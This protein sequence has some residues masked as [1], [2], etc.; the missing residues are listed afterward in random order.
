MN[1]AIILTKLTLI[2]ADFPVVNLITSE[3]YP[4]AIYANNLYYTFWVDSRSSPIFS[5][6][7]ARISTGGVVT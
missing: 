3:T 4:C 2:G 6:Y 5:L 1:F 7:G